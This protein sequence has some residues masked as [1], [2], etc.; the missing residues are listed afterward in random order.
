TPAER[1]TET[2]SNRFAAHIVAYKQL[3][4]LMK[5]RGWD[6]QMLGPWDSG[7]TTE[8]YRVLPGGTWR[9]G[10]RL[11]Y[12]GTRND[13]LECATTDRVGR[14]RREGGTWRRVPLAEA[15]P[16][17]FS[18]AMRDVDMFVSVTSIAGD[19]TWEDRGDDFGAYWQRASEAEL[20]ATAKVRRSA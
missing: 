12:Q 20:T 7:D 8:V 6:G 15:P 4:A 19:R 13:G 18:E 2:Y 5:G 1:D 3:Y 14:D 17:V 10:W 9:A 11:F 16:V